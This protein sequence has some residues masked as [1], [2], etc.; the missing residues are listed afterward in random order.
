MLVTLLDFHPV[1]V[2]LTLSAFSK[3]PTAN[4]A[5]DIWKIFIILVLLGHI[6]GI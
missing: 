3:E 5:I 4:L 2:F 1:I 6:I